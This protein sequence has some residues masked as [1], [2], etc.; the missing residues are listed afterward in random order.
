MT[1]DT[2]SERHSTPSGDEPPEVAVG[3]DPRKVP[4]V[5]NDDGGPVP[6]AGHLEEGVAHLHGSPTKGRCPRWPSRPDPGQ[7]LPPRAPPGGRGRNPR[8]GGPG[9]PSP[10]PRA[11]PRASWRCGAAER[12]QFRAS[13]L[14]R[15]VRRGD[16]R[17]DAARRARGIE[18]HVGVLGQGRFQATGNGDDGPRACGVGKDGEHLRRG[19]AVAQDEGGVVPA[20]HPRSP[21]EPS[22]A[23]RKKE[24][25]P[26]EAS[27]RRFS[28]R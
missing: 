25:V 4:P 5:V 2:A 23:C 1:P 21:W 24:G 18:D 19:P 28:C 10:S 11:S 20:D 22:A 3:E 16:L 13:S 7:Q 14:S 17:Q 12:G 8:G 26:R 15:A 9:V 6:L 27:S